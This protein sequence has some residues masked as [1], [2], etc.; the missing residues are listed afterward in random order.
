M[1]YSEKIGVRCM[2]ERFPVWA[3]GEHGMERRRVYIYLPDEYYEKP[4]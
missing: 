2:I 4:K 3:P 1:L